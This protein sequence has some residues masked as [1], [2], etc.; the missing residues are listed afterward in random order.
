LKRDEERR[1]V[2]ADAQRKYL[3][4][5]NAVLPEPFISEFEERFVTG[6]GDRGSTKSLYCHW[7]SAQKLIRTLQ[8]D[9]SSWFDSVYKIYDYFYEKCYSLSYIRKVIRYLNLWG[10]F[11]SRKLGR[12]FLPVPNPR[13]YERNRILD[14]YH[15]SRRSKRVE[16]D[17][18]TPAAL[19]QNKRQ[20]KVLNYN[21]LK[22]SVWL[23]LRPMEVDQLADPTKYRLAKCGKTEVLWIYQT[24][25]VSIPPEKRWKP[26]PLIF[27]EQRAVLDI[28]KTQ[29]FKRPLVKTVKHHFGNQ[30]TLYGGRKGFTDLMLA[31]G[32]RLE[33]ISQ[34]MGHSSIERTWRNYKDP[35]IVHYRSA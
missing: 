23:G 14:A 33:D 28:I 18:I 13:G 22:I 17:P 27:P 20:L 3:D 31:R 8:I 21:W 2:F 32:Q 7:R 15:S 34:W 4:E 26:I 29:A 12:A 24:K 35:R 5:S 19:I 25:L 30:T 10:F 9:P 1:L 11:I 6:R 16:S